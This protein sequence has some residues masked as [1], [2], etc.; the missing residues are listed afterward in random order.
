MFKAAKIKIEKT[1]QRLALQVQHCKTVRNDAMKIGPVGTLTEESRHGSSN[2]DTG[3][4]HLLYTWSSFY[5]CTIL[6]RVI[7]IHARTA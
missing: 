2:Y 6:C 7:I 5:Q 3:E 4:H 1:Q